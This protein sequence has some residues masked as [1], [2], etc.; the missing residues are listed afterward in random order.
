MRASRS[1]AQS[2]KPDMMK[3]CCWA[4]VLWSGVLVEYSERWYGTGQQFEEHPAVTWSRDARS[5]RWVYEDSISYRR[6]HRR[7]TLACRVRDSSIS[8]RHKSWQ[9]P[10]THNVTR[11]QPGPQSSPHVNARPRREPMASRMG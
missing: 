9:I 4:G 5:K 2:E 8:H 3:M 10:T 1:S 7:F 6:P 11:P